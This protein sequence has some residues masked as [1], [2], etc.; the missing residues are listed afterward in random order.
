MCEG[1]NDGFKLKERITTRIRGEEEEEDEEHLIPLLKIGLYGA[2]HN[3]I[4]QSEWKLE[5]DF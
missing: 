5:T 3:C 2:A 4:A 1:H